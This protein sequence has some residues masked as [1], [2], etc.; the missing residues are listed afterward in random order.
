M[1]QKDERLNADLKHKI[2]TTAPARSRSKLKEVITVHM[3]LIQR[4]PERV[5]KY[6]GDPHLS[7]AAKHSI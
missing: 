5:I 7:Y 1:V 3:E 4:S 6:F 2:T